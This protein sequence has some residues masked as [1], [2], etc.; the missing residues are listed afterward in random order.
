[1]ILSPL[2]RNSALDPKE[3]F[4]RLRKDGFAR[5]RID[6]KIHELDTALAAQSKGLIS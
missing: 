6:G 1:M 5:V 2:S 4:N 3:Q